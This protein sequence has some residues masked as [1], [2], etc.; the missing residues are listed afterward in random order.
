MSVDS[1][2]KRG[3]AAS[4]VDGRK[5]AEVV[6]RTERGDQPTLPGYRSGTGHDHEGLAAEGA[7]PDDGLAREQR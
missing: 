5:L 7:L 6:A 1:A 4:G 2:V 3:V